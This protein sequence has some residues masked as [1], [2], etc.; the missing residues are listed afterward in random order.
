[1]SLFD[2]SID[3]EQRVFNLKSYKIL[4]TPVEN[5]FDDITLLASV[6]CDAPYCFIGFMDNERLWFK[7][8][9]GLNISEISLDRS[10]CKYV[11]ASKRS[12]LIE[13]LESDNQ[14]ADSC[15]TQNGEKIRFYLGLPFK[16]AEGF[17]LGTLVVMDAKPRKLDEKQM[18]SL[19][20]LNRQIVQN[21]ML[22]KSSMQNLLTN[23]A[24]ALGMFSFSLAH[25]INNAL[26][27]SDGYLYTAIKLSE[28]QKKSDEKILNL[29]SKI[30]TTNSRISKIVNGIKKFS[31]NAENDPL[32]IFSVKKIIEDT[33][34]ICEKKC[35]QE[36]ISLR[37]NIPDD[38][39]YIE[40]RPSEII[41]VLINLINNSIDAMSEVSTKWI[42]LEVKIIG[43]HISFDVK[44]GGRGIPKEIVHNL[45]KYFCTTKDP[46]KGT[47]LGLFICKT[48]IEHH[49]GHFFFD[50]NLP[51]SFG[52]ILPLKLPHNAK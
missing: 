48:I 25:E 40:C 13:D 46:G 4:D 52:F 17:I 15:L 31:R 33:L 49:S 47:G 24:S 1:M 18:A 20:A 2:K 41:Q 7:S 44:D 36:K 6:I 23:K 39:F 9:K 35:G 27:A 34:S 19:M 8:K 12:L 43:D 21:L 51:T 3:E 14:F 45:T 30:K 16:S 11:L 28:G 5:E 38:D 10:L 22:R 32:E 50:A 42:E 26:F 29:L 37:I